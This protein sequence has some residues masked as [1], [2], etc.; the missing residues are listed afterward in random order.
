MEEVET[1]P[2]NPSCRHAWHLYI[3]RLN[4][5]RLKID[6]E[7]FIRELRQRGIGTSVHFIPIPLHPFFARQPLAR[8]ACPRAMQLYPRIVSLPLYPAMTEEQIHYV[9]QSVQEVLECSRRVRFVASG[10]VAADVPLNASDV[11]TSFRRCL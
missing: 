3:L 7:E 2:D 5:Q 1:P 11:S 4:L 9:A 6:R 8:Y 10:A